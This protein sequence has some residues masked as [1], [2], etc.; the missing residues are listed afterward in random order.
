[1]SDALSQWAQSEIEH[2][3]GRIFYAPHSRNHSRGWIF[4]QCVGDAARA[5]LA[6][7]SATMRTL[8]GY[9]CR[10]CGSERERSPESDRWNDCLTPNCAGNEWRAKK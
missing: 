9:G 3:D 7:R 6:T 4:W 2:D 10:H 8:S 5:E 1:M